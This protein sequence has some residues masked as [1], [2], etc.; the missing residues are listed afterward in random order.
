MSAPYLAIRILLQLVSDKER[1]FSARNAVRKHTYVD[2]MLASGD[3]LEDGLE[4]KAQREQ[5]L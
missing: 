2:N 5:L 3:T 1:R 4:V